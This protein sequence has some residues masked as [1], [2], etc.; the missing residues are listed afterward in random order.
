ML[1]RF[2]LL[3]S[4]SC[5]WLCL[6]QSFSDW[7]V[8]QNGSSTDLQFNIILKYTI[9]VL[10]QC[11][12]DVQKSWRCLMAFWE[13]VGVFFCYLYPCW[14]NAGWNDLFNYWLVTNSLFSFQFN[15]MAPFQTWSIGGAEKRLLNFKTIKLFWLRQI[16][17]HICSFPQS[18]QYIVCCVKTRSV[19]VER[20]IATRLDICY[21]KN[22]LNHKEYSNST[23]S[24]II[25]NQ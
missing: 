20:K 3:E 15:R 9:L 7:E 8:H 18:K 5:S 11:W 6:W 21:E 10:M 16:Q 12:A 13:F 25:I 22:L 2:H 23:A 24:A 17:M 4:L 14:G 1:C 19:L